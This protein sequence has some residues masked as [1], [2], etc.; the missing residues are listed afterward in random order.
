M[1]GDEVGWRVEEDGRVVGLETNEKI[2]EPMAA[3]T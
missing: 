2:L 1:G 3:V